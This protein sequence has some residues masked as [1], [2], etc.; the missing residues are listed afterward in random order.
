MFKNY[1]YL[2]NIT[3]NQKFAQNNNELNIEFY[4]FKNAY[5]LKININTYGNNEIQCNYSQLTKYISCHP[6]IFIID[7]II[8]FIFGI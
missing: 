4:S 3:K 8:I 5:N 7:K 1:I 6:V 2:E